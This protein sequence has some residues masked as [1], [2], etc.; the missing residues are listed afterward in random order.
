MPS[1]NKLDC[2][3]TIKVLSWY[4]E[5]VLYEKEVTKRNQDWEKLRQAESYPS[6]SSIGPGRH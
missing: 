4:G 1:V 6:K 3:R 5:H 2:I